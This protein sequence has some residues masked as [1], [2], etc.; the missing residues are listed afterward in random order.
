M[1]SHKKSQQLDLA[2]E[3]FCVSQCGWIRFFSAVSM[4]VTINN[5]WKLF[6]FLIKKE[7]Y[8][9]F[10]GIREFSERLAMDCFINPFTTD[11]GTLANSI[12]SLD[13]IDN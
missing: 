8:D 2:M 4:G 12:P 7:H 1:D 3:N 5:C 10:I 9:K 6:F 13:D 11:T